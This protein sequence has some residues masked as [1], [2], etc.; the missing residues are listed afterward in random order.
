MAAPAGTPRA[1]V[2]RLNRDLRAAVAADDANHRLVSQGAVPLSST[3]EEYVADI[4]AD[5]KKWSALVKSLNLKF[6]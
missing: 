6:E 4:D 1:I 3:S 5:E 2:E